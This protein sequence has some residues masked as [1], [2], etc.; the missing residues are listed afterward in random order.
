MPNSNASEPSKRQIQYALEA[1]LASST[2]ADANRVKTF[3]SYIIEE[4][5]DGRGANIRAK[6][7]AADVYGRRPED[8]AEQEAIVRVDAGR[9]R[10]RLDV[11]YSDEGARDAVRI[12]VLS[13]GYMPTF[14]AIEFAEPEDSDQPLSIGKRGRA[15][16]VFSLL[17]GGI[18]GIG[19]GWFA[20]GP[21]DGLASSNP[22]STVTPADQEERL[23]RSSVN[24]ISSASLL[25]RTFVE[26][27]R[28]L[29]FPSIDIARLE[30][31]EILCQRAIELAPELSTGHACDAFAQAFMAFVLPEG[32][33]RSS[34]L[35][36]AR[37]EAAAALRNDPADAYAQMAEAWAQFVGGERKT[38]IERARAAVRIAPEEDFLLNFYGMMMAFDGQ[39][40]ELLSSQFLEIDGKTPADLYHPFILAG[41]KFQVEDYS[42]AIR[43]IQDAIEL[44]GRTSVLMAAIYVA[45]LE[46]NGNHKAAEQFARNLMNTWQPVQFRRTIAS[47]FSNEPEVLAIVVPLEGVMVRMNG[48]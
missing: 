24:Q 22:Q 20:N 4:T 17:V 42:G 32:A 31:A 6:L 2:F 34:R 41:V 7:I 48:E 1:V 3:L 36:R 37:K 27:A 13:G 9:L 47:L 40:S 8:G 39:G 45:A 46:N 30:A 10:R 35:L 33:L 26:D 25:A 18:L 11:Y 38:S 44:E 43:A 12:H 29:I 21:A 16:F 15:P 23:I 14:E 5:L 19:I 28:E